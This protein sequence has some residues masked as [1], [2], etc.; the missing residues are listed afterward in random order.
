MKLPQHKYLS[1]IDCDPD[2]LVAYLDSLMGTL[3]VYYVL[4]APEN[5][6]GRIREQLKKEL[7]FIDK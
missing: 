6:Q 1:E 7:G 5:A 2:R 4:T 3:A